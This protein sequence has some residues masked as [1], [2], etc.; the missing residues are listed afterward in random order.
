MNATPYTLRTTCRVCGSSRLEPILSLGE[1][2]VSDFVAGDGSGPPPLRAPLDLVLCNP[3]AGGCSLLQ[4]SCTV[5]PE[6]LYRQYWYK[7][8]VNQTM[9]D[10]L[11]DVT[12]AAKRLAKLKLSAG[13][14]VVDIGA[15]DGTLLRS[16]GVDG[17]TLVGFEPA[18][19]LAPE[20]AVGTT[21][22][23]NDF[24]N[25]GAFFQH[26]PGK[27][28]KVI[29]SCAMFY[30]L[31]DPN[32]FVG[33][34]KRLL[35]EDGVFII[36]QNYL[37]AMLNDNVFDNIMHE[38]LEYYSLQSLQALMRRQQLEIFDVE[39]NDVNGGSFRTYIAHAGA[40][41]IHDRVRAML[42]SEE[43]LR[44]TQ[45]YHEFAERV[46]RLKSTVATFIRQEAA[47]GKKIY[48][49]GASTRGN[50]LLQ[51][52]GLD[53][54]LITA[55]AERNPIKY[56]RRTVGSNILIVSEEQARREK[57]DYFLVLPWA[58]LEEFR[59]READYFKGGGKFLVPLP[60]FRIIDS[61]KDA[62]APVTLL[63]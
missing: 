61:P 33:D 35:A 58:F 21:R 50:T 55:A 45:T 11:T 18:R 39:T 9:R 13:D 34:V 32:T 36:Q 53:H 1:M 29:T 16:Y 25:A 7:S 56:G 3:E 42:K 37:L 27:Q 60:E 48:V 43:G 57:P 17:L 30:D 2:Y 15:N 24:F 31:E 6:R 20:A 28:A 26:F 38:H 40:R 5:S 41:A 12:R 59:Q 23:I 10:A 4:L 44:R 8:S 19:N 62:K 46:K 54:T 47:Q 14:L 49:Y 22:I 63:R 51:Y 52:F